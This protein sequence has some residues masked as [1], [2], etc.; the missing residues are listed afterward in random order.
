MEL[1]SFE[2]QCREAR[3]KKHF[4]NKRDFG[5]EDWEEAGDSLIN[6]KQN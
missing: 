3:A 5:G 1:I 4:K 2:T 6:N